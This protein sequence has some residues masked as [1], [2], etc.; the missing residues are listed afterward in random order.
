M[1]TL[2]QFNQDEEEQT[3]QA[4]Q[5]GGGGQ[6]LSS[7]EGEVSGGAGAQGQAAG[8]SGAPQRPTLSN[9]PN[10]QQYLQAN[11]GAGEQLA[12][13]IQGNVQRQADELGQNVNTFDQQLDTKYNPLYQTEQQG[14]QVIQS[15]FQ[16]PEQLLNAYNASQ[17]QQQGQALSEDQQNSLNQYNQFQAYNN[18]N[19]GGGLN[20]QISNYGSA[21]QNA[22]ANLQNQ[23][24]GLNQ[25]IGQ[26]N[27]ETGRFGLLQ[28]AVGQPSYNQGQQTLDALFLQAQPGVTRQ[29]QQNLG[30]IGQ[31]S[32]Q[33]ITDLGTEAQS[34]LRALQ[35]LSSQ[36]ERSVKDTF[37]GGVRDIGRNVKSSYE[38]LAATVPQQ[39]ES[40]RQGVLNNRLTPEQLAQLGHNSA[41]DGQ[42]HT[43]GLSGQDILNAGQFAANPL[44][45]G[46]AGGYAQAATPE[47]FARYNALNQLAGG[48]S[49]LE[50]NMFGTAQTAGGYNPITFNHNNLLSAIQGRKDTVLG[51]DMRNA[52]NQIGPNANTDPV[53]AA[54]R[55]RN[56]PPEQAKN[57]IELYGQGLLS[58]QAIDFSNPDVMDRI[59]D[60]FAL[61]PINNPGEAL[62]DLARNG[63]IGSG[64]SYRRYTPQEYYNAIMPMFNPFMNY[65]NQ[66]YTPAANATLSSN[67]SPE[68]NPLPTNKDGSINWGGIAPPTGSAGKY[69]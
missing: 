48:P 54:I 55:S 2:A 62:K 57:L 58:S 69:Q 52:L 63:P 26:A 8:T 64:M 66:Q 3:N 29:L 53:M 42:L 61:G 9:K 17:N 24:Q 35:G 67:D 1:A 19:A 41:K 37:T 6:V 16:N 51:T 36:N 49:G 10:I 47:E 50:A 33:Q 44:L 68:A 34:K 5:T 40:M 39:Q 27:T 59:V 25:Q 28:Q 46:N 22:T 7:T 15:A 30:N 43:W 38:N 11:Q 12:G 45:A 65:Y 32:R 14:S 60:R 18:P 23:Y 31:Q 21:G 20:Q 13:G 56:L 4:E